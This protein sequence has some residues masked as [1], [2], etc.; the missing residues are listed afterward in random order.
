MRNAGRG[1]ARPAARHSDRRQGQLRN[2]RH[3]DHRRL[4][5]ACRL[6]DRTRRVS[7][8]EAAR[9]RRDHHRQD[10]PA[11]AGRRHH[12]DQ[13]AR[14]QTRNPYDPSR[15]PGGSSGGTGAAVAASFA[16]A[17]MGSDTCGSI[18]I[19]SANNNLVGPARN[20]PGCRAA[21]GIIP[22]SHTQDIGG[23]LARTVTDLAI[24][25]DATVGADRGDPTTTAS[26]RGTFPRAIATAFEA[27]RAERERIGVLKNLF[28]RA[29]RKK[30]GRCN[31][32]R[33]ARRDEGGRRRGRG[34]HR[35]RSRR[36]AARIECDQLGVQVRSDGLPG[37]VPDAPVHSLGEILER[38]DY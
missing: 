3:A 15:N 35:P 6:R 24:M 9:R 5:R 16:A 13:L 36:A 10:E 20:A 8:Q 23:P 17:G 19:P 14:R 31:R 37:A 2:R 30:R 21:R 22:L 18:R 12:H 32:P 29:R 34:R 7:G 38:G 33:S 28:G 26:Q 27:R 4:D 25:L 1:S 11:R